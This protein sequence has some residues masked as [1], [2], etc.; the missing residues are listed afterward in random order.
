[1]VQWG[2]G[3]TARPPRNLDD[4]C[5][6][7]EERR[8]WYR[9]ARRSFDRW[10]IPIHI[11]LAIVHQE[12]RFDGEARPPRRRILWVIPGPRRSDAHGYAQ[13]LK[14][15]WKEYRADSGNGG[16]DRDDFGDAVDFIGWYGARSARVAGISRGDAFNLY[17]AYH[18][19]DGGFRRG[20]Y[21]RKPWLLDIAAR[22]EHRAERYRR[23]LL[24]CEDR[25]GPRW[26]EFWH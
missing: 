17:L 24:T 20:T 25:L 13:A 7:L 12:S 26:W 19:G 23:Q 4:C 5:E 1:M 16:A 14:V 6:I 8:G 10:G 15:T 3:C 18:E 2:A 21:R 11:Q 22:V 9:A